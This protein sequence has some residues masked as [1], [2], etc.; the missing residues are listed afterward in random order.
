[1]DISFRYNPKVEQTREIKQNTIK[2]STFR[3]Q[4]KNNSQN[5]KKILNKLAAQG[6]GLLKSIMICNF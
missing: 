4:N 5:N 2:K 1:M 6:F 3:K